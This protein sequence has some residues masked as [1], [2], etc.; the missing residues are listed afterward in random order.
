MTRVCV[1]FEKKLFLKLAFE[2]TMCDKN[3][4][5]NWNTL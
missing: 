1:K 4:E 2:H 5:S 3:K